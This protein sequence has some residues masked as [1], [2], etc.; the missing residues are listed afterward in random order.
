MRVNRRRRR[1]LTPLG[2]AFM[3]ASALAAAL[4]GSSARAATGD[5]ATPTAGRVLQPAGFVPG[6]S[7]LWR[8]LNSSLCL[9]YSRLDLGADWQDLCRVPDDDDFVAPWWH[10]QSVGN[11][12][13]EIVNENRNQCLTVKDASTNDGATVLIFDCHGDASQVFSVSPDP[14]DR[15]ATSFQFRNV[16]SGK[17]VSVG[18]ASRFVEAWVIQWPCANSPE[19]FWTPGR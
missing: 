15:T 7:Y 17:C 13:F 9:D 4:A 19:F 10:M 8:N 14:S 1:R 5:G 16:H 3:A 18:G 2:A 12:T 11:N 6:R